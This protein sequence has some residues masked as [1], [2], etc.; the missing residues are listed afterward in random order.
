MLSNLH[1]HSTFCDGVN[2]P[3]EMV[4]AAINK[5]FASIGFSSHAKPTFSPFGV[6][7]INEYILRIKEFKNKYSDEIEIYIGIEEDALSPIGC[8]DDFEYII[9]SHHYIKKDDIILPS[10]LNFDGFKKTL[11]LFDNDIESFAESYYSDFCKYIKKYKPQIIGHFDLITKFD[12][13]NSNLLLSNDK[14]NKIAEKYLKSV[15]P[16][17]CL[18]EVNTGAMARKFRTCPYPAVNLLKI[19]RDND[20]KIIISSDAH[21][22]DCLDYA[23]GDTIDLLK[24]IGF[25]HTYVLKGN[26]FVKQEI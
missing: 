14:Y 8:R 2:T 17:G 3:E 1:T 23:F 19:I 24:D 16:C 7:D 5:G 10:D 18:F 20:G 21:S 26:N 25:K 6:N 22:A 9:G 13:I 15:L 12:E 4:V 11:E